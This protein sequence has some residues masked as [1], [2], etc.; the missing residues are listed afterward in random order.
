MATYKIISD[1]GYTLN[2][3]A[4]ASISA[5]LTGTTYRLG[6]L[7]EISRIQTNAPGAEW[8]NTPTGWIATMWNS[9][10]RVELVTISPPTTIKVPFTLTVSGFVPFTGEL[11]QE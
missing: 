3:R 7:V 5:P 6:D 9:R 11:E 8:G 2:E 4:F 1:I 10:E